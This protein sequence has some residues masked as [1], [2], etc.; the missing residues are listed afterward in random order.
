MRKMRERE[1]WAGEDRVSGGEWREAYRG[2]A[3]HGAT[4]AVESVPAGAS[5]AATRVRVGEGRT[6]W[7]LKCQFCPWPLA[8]PQ[9][10]HRV[11]LP[12]T[13]TKDDMWDSH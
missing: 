2:L 5:L 13:N 8:E 3:T 12:F 7:D 10:C 4:A 9:V 11:S 6:K 1:E